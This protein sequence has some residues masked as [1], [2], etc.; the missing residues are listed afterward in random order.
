MRVQGI[1]ITQRRRAHIEQA[2]SWQV[3]RY[4]IAVLRGVSMAQ[5]EKVI[6]VEVGIVSCTRVAC[7]GGLVQE[8]MARKTNGYS[9]SNK[10]N[11]NTFNFL[12]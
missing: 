9:K 3:G 11:R 7:Y 4:A 10:S 5:R 2:K 8:R 1:S 12:G 6:R